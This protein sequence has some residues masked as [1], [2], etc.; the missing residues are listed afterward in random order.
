MDRQSG[1]RPT[2]L[3]SCSLQ[4]DP[5]PNASRCLNS[6]ASIV[7]S[8]LQVMPKPPVAESSQALVPSSPTLCFVNKALAGSSAPLRHSITNPT[9][10][11][12]NYPDI[13]VAFASHHV[14]RSA[15]E[16]GSAHHF[17]RRPQPARARTAGERRIHD[18][19]MRFVQFPKR[20][21]N[22][23]SPILKSPDV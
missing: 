2:K 23:C 16:H 11:L 7:L 21:A 22:S 14:L 12:R 6:W 1:V 3:N 18:T 9:L 19:G 4:Y 15:H 20:I 5:P 10:S 17:P 8:A 13:I